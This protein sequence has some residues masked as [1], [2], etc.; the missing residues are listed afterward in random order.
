[1][2]D[3]H[4][5]AVG[6]HTH[7]GTDQLRGVALAVVAALDDGVKQLSTGGDLCVSLRWASNLHRLD[8]GA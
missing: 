1:V 6:H 5:V 7:N 4:V 8:D 3:A 2:D